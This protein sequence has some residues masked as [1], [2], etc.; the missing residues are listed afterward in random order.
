VT[1]VSASLRV[2]V[3]D[4]HPLFREGVVATLSRASGFVA[5]GEA[6]S[7]AQAVSQISALRPDIVLLDVGLPDGRGVEFIK[8]ILDGSP[9]SRVIMLTVAD[10][11]DTV[12]EALRAGA[13]GYLLK[14]ISGADII[15]A[16]QEV[17]H[18][19]TYASPTVAM[20]VLRDV[21]GPASQPRAEELTVRENEVLK[22]LAEGLTNR[23]I[24]SRLYLSEKTVKHHVTIVLQKLGVRNRVEAALVA[25]K[26]RHT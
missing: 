15:A 14:G 12:V 8:P 25:S 7:G 23:E 10:D 11:N 13:V 3:V 4:D 24:G 22:L 5:V 19:S 26:G 1:D 21:L 6:S 16:V 9:Q 17:A 20:R 18:G 2:F